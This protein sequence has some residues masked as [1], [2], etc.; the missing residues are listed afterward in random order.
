M[1]EF[2]Q[3]AIDIHLAYKYGKVYPEGDR[4]YKIEFH[5]VNTALQQEH[6]DNRDSQ[7]NYATL[8]T[9]ILDAVSNNTTLANSE[10]FKRYLF[11]NI[12]EIDE[13]ISNS[14]VAELKAK[15]DEDSSMM[16]SILKS[17]PEELAHILES[18]F[19]EG[20]NND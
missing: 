17:T 4:P 5:S 1:E 3:R 10:A 2:I 15:G 6:N 9:Q 20:Q 14:L 8:I 11:S 19:K 18:V 13:N 16:D 7:A 12:L